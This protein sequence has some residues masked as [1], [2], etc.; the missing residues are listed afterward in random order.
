MRISSA[1][2]VQRMEW[3]D[4]CL[5]LELMIV[6]RKVFLRHYAEIVLKAIVT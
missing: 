2:F 6:Y 5:K 1:T 4:V 3:D